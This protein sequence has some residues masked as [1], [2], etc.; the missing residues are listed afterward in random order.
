MIEISHFA[1]SHFLSHRF[2]S[3]KKLQMSALSVMEEER[4]VFHLH[5]ILQKFPLKSNASNSTKQRR[6]R[7]KN[8]GKF[9]TTI[10]RIHLS[11]W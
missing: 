6:R 9:S 7:K 2:G 4:L 1:T 11:R 3:D 5:V 8:L 10:K